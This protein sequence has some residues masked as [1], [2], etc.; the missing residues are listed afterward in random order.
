MNK[1]SDLIIPIIIVMILCIGLYKSKDV[2]GIFC[3]GVREGMQITIDI[4]PSILGLMMAIEMLNACGAIEVMANFFKPILNVIGMP[5]EVLP[6][7]LL[8]PISGS[9]S[10]GIVN[11]VFSSAGVDS[12]A[13]KVASVMMGSTETTFYTI[14]LFYGAVKERI[15]ANV[16]VSALAG[17]FAA[18]VAS[19][20]FCRIFL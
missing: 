5:E 18:M 15:D 3:S 9:A 8:R 11:N 2:Y 17:D 4:F 1:V 20:I 12:Y 13:G 19:I 7:A 14:A 6:L 16:V 10:I